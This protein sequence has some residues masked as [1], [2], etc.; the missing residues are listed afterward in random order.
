MR[1]EGKEEAIKTYREA[2]VIDPIID[3]DLA[4]R[5]LERI[6]RRSRAE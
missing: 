3:R 6:K 1:E 4:E 2:A 5:A